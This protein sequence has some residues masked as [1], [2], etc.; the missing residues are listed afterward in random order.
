[1]NTEIIISPVANGWMISIP[2]LSVNDDPTGGML[3]VL[4]GILKHMQ[5]PEAVI[6]EKEKEKQ[7]MVRNQSVFVFDSFEKVLAF[8]AKQIT[9]K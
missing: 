7:P 1:M 5:D 9:D 4:P 8:L 2:S 6:E 3:K